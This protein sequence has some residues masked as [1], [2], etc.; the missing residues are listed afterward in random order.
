MFH[1]VSSCRPL[2]IDELLCVLR[3]TFSS[4]Y[5][6]RPLNVDLNC[7]PSFAKNFSWSAIILKIHFPQDQ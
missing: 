2:Y 5:P 1:G 3:R 6:S 4:S 7:F